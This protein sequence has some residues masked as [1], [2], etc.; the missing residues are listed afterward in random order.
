MMTVSHS[1]N[2]RRRNKPS[3]LL[4]SSISEITIGFIKAKYSI[5]EGDPALPVQVGVTEG[6]LRSEVVLNVCLSQS[7]HSTEGD[8]TYSNP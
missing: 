4:L 5:R 8:Y 3:D 1:Y 6:I 7:N 2:V